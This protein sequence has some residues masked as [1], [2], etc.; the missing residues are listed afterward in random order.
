VVL[1]QKL[2]DFFVGGNDARLLL[3]K[4]ELTPHL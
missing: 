1:R 4:L 3:E 2:R